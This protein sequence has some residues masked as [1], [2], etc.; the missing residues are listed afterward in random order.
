MA[1]AY[2]VRP[3]EIIFIEDE[4]TAYCFDEA[5]SYIISQLKN[6]KKP[7]FNSKSK[8]IKV[9]YNKL[10]DLYKDM[11]YEKNQYSRIIE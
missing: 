6:K 11:G 7:R 1:Q 5:C 2:N 3:S 9:R 10:S 4:Y 8:E